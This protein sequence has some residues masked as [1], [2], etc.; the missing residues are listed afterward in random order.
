MAKPSEAARKTLIRNLRAYRPY[1]SQQAFHD[2]RCQFKGFSGPVGSGKSNALVYEAIRLAYRNRGRTGLIA[3]P[4]IPMLRDAT[5]ASFLAVL[6]DEGVPFRFYSHPRNLI[7]LLEPKSDILFRSMSEPERL[8]GTN[9]AW[10][11]VDELTY[12]KEASWLRLEARLRDPEAREQIGFA[13]WTPKGYDWVYGRFIDP[14]RS[15]GLKA[16]YQAIRAVPGESASV[17]GTAYYER[18]RQSYD[19]RF[20]AQE[21]LGEYLSIFSGQVYSSFDRE[22]NVKS[23][24]YD[25]QL[26]LVWALDFNIEPMSSVLCQEVPGSAHQ[27]VVHVLDE[28]VI[29][30][31]TTQD[32]C[33]EFEART[34]N[35]TNRGN[36]RLVVYG[37]PAGNSGSTQS[38][39]SDWD[40]VRNFF[41]N[42]TRYEVSFRI[43]RS[44]PL[45]RDRVNAVNGKLRNAAGIRRMFIDPR[46]RELIRDFEQVQYKS[47]PN[48]RILAEI[49]KSDPKRTHLSDALGYYIWKEFPVRSFG[50]SGAQSKPLF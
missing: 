33:N 27:P 9:L 23:L 2:L 39:V 29:P 3:A 34:A 1:P 22:L 26:P 18:L 8:R 6:E 4:T 7:R 28:L 44:H 40:L 37:D 10:F 20:F 32:A 42:Q 47:D 41:R 43:D 21:A 11:A 13:C 25:P 30:S 50:S 48:G 36:I 31:S 17:I 15:Q 12:C 16:A 49:D 38:R 45:V 14:A 24:T 19:E 5:Q 46:C 35:W